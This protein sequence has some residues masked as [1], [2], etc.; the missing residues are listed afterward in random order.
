MLYKVGVAKIRVNL[1]RLR[2]PV[3]GPAR[4]G[5]L[6]AFSIREC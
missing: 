5:F 6:R 3:Y 2:Q 1:G 4:M